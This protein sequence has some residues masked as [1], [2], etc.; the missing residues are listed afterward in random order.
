MEYTTK[1]ILKRN[2]FNKVEK[3]INYFK[4]KGNITEEEKQKIIKAIVIVIIICLMDNLYNNVTETSGIESLIKLFGISDEKA[5]KIRNIGINS[6]NITTLSI[7]IYK[8]LV[9]EK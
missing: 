3:L 2:A 5:K 1:D 6:A 4:S 9:S 7:I 8:Y